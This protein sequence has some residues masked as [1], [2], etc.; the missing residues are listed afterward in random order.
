VGA[1]GGTAQEPQDK[2]YGLLVECADDQGMRFQ[3]WQPR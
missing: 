3:L 2:P 1:A